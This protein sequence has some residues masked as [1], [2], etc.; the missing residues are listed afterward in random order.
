MSAQYQLLSNLDEYYSIGFGE[1]SLALE[2]LFKTSYW[3]QNAQTKTFPFLYFVKLSTQEINRIHFKY[4]LLKV[5]VSYGLLLEMLV[6][7]AS[8]FPWADSYLTSHDMHNI[9]WKIYFMWAKI[10]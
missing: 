1:I 7:F 8:Y 4:S 2:L 9:I 3:K 5:E 6:V 10:Y